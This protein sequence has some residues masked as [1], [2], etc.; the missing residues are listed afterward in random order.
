MIQGSSTK[1][2]S[3]LGR[4]NNLAGYHCPNYFYKNN[5]GHGSQPNYFSC[6]NNVVSVLDP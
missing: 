3:L 5:L 6:L 4:K 2:T 1:I